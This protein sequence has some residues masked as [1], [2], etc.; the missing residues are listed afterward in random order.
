MQFRDFT[1]GARTLA[2][3][4]V[5][6]ATAIITIALGLGASTAIFSVANTVLLRPL[7][8][9]NPDR[10]VFAISDMRKRN[11]K[12]FP[13][14][15][16]DFIDM[17]NGTGSVFQ[18]LGGVFTGRATVPREDD[19][20]E[21]IHWAIVTPNFFH[22]MGGSIAVGRDFNDADGLPQPAPPAGAIPA[23]A[24]PRLPRMAILSYA[25]WQHRFGGRPDIIGRP[26]PGTGQGATQIVGVLKPG[27]ELFFP[28]DATEEQHPDIWFANRL[29][30]DNAGRNGVSLRAIGRL[31]DDVA[32]GRAQSAVDRVADQLRRNFII[33]GTSGFFI[34]LD[35]MHRHV[36][37]EVRPALLALMGAVVFLLLIACANVANLLLVRASLRERELAVRTALGG[38]WWRL[39][40]QTLA[41]AALLAFSGAVLGLGLAW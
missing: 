38:S 39:V 35:P 29:N 3:S 17:R 12:D 8:Y 27:F 15:N 20:P 1:Y 28:P 37:E 13:F 7:P 19:T 30:Y 6:A 36:V 14:S 26:M 22:L 25:Y 23:Q 5:F 16:A 21:Q 31:R 34:R 4:P 41:E 32:I 40:S 24:P 11:V 10:L 18:E 2:K 33:H 9:R